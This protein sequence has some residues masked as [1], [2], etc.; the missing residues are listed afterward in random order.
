KFNMLPDLIDVG[1]AS[2]AALAD[3]DGDGNLDLVVGGTGSVHLFQGLGTGKFILRRI[4]NLPGGNPG[5]PIL[6]AT[7]IVI[8]DFD[9]DRRPDIAFAV[10]PA[11]LV[12]IQL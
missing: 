8:G 7:S 5:D 4:T 10:S 3:F 6:T 9:G 12:F 2:S 1:D 11:A